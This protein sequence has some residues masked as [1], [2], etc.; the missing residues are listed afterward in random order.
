MKKLLGVDFGEEKT[1]LAISYE[2]LAEPL[3]VVK[4]EKA[5]ARIAR[6]AKK[7]KVEAIIVGIS[8]GKQ[9]QKTLQFARR[10]SWYVKA[11]VLFWDETLTTQEAKKKAIEAKIKKGKRKRLEDAFAAAIMLQSYLDRTVV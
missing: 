5:V 4:T 8:E 1:G 7:E 10:L 11:P 3:T 2:K 6:V 9:A